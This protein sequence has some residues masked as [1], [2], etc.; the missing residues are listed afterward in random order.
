VIFG[1]SRNDG[2]EDVSM[3]DE[4]VICLV[5]VLW[6]AI[7]RVRQTEAV[8]ENELENILSMLRIKERK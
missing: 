2:D 8:G 6:N 1:I 5:H 3:I 7:V 4:G